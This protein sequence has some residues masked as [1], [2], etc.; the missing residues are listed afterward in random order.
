MQELLGTRVVPEYDPALARRADILH[1]VGDPTRLRQATGWS[2][3]IHL[4]QT[5][6]DL[7]DAQAD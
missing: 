5:L 1:L 7:L 3:R 6:Q 4:D 2:P